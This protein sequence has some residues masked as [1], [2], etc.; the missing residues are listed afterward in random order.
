L[1]SVLKEHTLSE[2]EKRKIVCHE[3][4]GNETKENDNTQ[5]VPRLF[6][7]TGWYFFVFPGPADDGEEKEEGKEEKPYW[8][9]AMGRTRVSD[10]LS[11]STGR[12]VWREERIRKTVVR[13]CVLV[14]RRCFGSWTVG[15]VV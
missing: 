2:K 8:G 5:A 6:F 3:P 12:V 14:R 9:L 15:R 10:C 7:L 13:V 11:R 1:L 4:R